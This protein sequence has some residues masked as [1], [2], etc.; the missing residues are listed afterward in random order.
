MDAKTLFEE[1]I[2]ECQNCAQKDNLEFCQANCK[3]HV[4]KNA[5]AKAVPLRFHKEKDTISRLTHYF[6]KNCGEFS[7]ASYSNNPPER[8][9]YCR[10]CGQA[11]LFEKEKD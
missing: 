1:V 2:M 8:I 4:I 10:N 11:F 3:T 5:L 9:H 7:H 6:C